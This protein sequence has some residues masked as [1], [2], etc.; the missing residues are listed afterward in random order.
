MEAFLREATGPCPALHL[1]ANILRGE[2]VEHEGIATSAYPSIA[3]TTNLALS[4]NQVK[5][6]STLPA[7][8]TLLALVHDPVHIVSLYVANENIIINSS[9]AYSLVKESN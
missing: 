6:I 1:S 9:T 2:R 5:S 3:L 8:F 7:W 4:Q